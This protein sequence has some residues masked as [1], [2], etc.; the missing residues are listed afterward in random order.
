MRA[1]SVEVLRR[2]KLAP[3]KLTLS[4][5]AMLGRAGADRGFTT[6]LGFTGAGAGGGA[7]LGAGATTGAGVGTCLGAEA[8]AARAR[9][10]KAVRQ[11]W[12]LSMEPRLLIR[13]RPL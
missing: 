7:G 13:S 8:Q 5:A 3:S 9:M 4:A 12:T 2:M 11:R 10:S 1:L 6:G